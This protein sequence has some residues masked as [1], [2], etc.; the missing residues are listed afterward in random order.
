MSSSTE[1]GAHSVD[2]IRVVVDVPSELLEQPLNA[3]IPADLQLPDANDRPVISA[4][5]AFAALG[6]DR[7]TGY[8]AIRDGTF[9]LPVIRVGRVIRVPTIAL[10]QLLASEP[11]AST[12]PN[13]GEAE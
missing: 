6:I 3:T 2:S 5:E 9:P 13:D 10:G 12:D 7:S 11:P 1:S 4:E 8:R